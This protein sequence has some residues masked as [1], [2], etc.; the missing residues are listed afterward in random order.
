MLNRFADRY[1]AMP[2]QIIVETADEIDAS[3]GARERRR[4][5]QSRNNQDNRRID[6]LL[7]LL[8]QPRNRTGAVRVKLWLQQ[9]GRISLDAKSNPVAK[10]GRVVVDRD[11]LCPYS[12]KAIGLDA[13]FDAG[14]I[15]I[16][17]IIPYPQSLDNRLQNLALSYAGENLQKGNR[18][19]YEALRHDPARLETMKAA[20]AIQ[21]RSQRW[22]YGPDALE[23]YADETGGF[24]PRH[25]QDTRYGARVARRYLSTVADVVSVKGALTAMLR[26][27]WGLDSLI[28]EIGGFVPDGKA[29]E[30]SRLD[31]RHHAIDAA[32]LAVVDRSLVQRVATA[33]RRWNLAAGRQEA[34]EV[35]LPWPT[36]REDLKERLQRLV[37]SHQPD[38][39]VSGALH[40][41]TL[42]GPPRSK[43]ARELRADGVLRVSLE[44]MT[45][46]QAEEVL[47]PEARAKILDALKS[48]R[49]AERLAAEAE[50][51]KARP[52]SVAAAT[53]NIDFGLGT[54]PQRFRVAVRKSSITVIG[55]SGAERAVD[56]SSVHRVD[57]YE[58][59][60]GG[61][62]CVPMTMIDAAREEQGGRRS[63]Q[64]TQS[65]VRP[66]L[67]LHRGDTIALLDKD[68][69]SRVLIRVVKR[70]SPSD[71]N[72]CVMLASP[73]LAMSDSAYLEKVPFSA[74]RKR[75]ARTVSVC[76]IGDV[77]GLGELGTLR[78]E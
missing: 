72:R 73:C 47:I 62:R 45:E 26:R 51:R 11:A 60:K 37:V 53:A 8:R 71:S 65:A 52:V 75:K 40:N 7:D 76:P 57:F 14:T 23:R 19:P 67:S 33:I 78:R 74:L 64:R 10:D 56:A 36:F 1:G 15:Q 21:P 27:A 20:V 48:A 66:V 41:E 39:G 9:G 50:G 44:R 70:L 63:A 49:D 32:V 42:Y 69:P 5:N 22:R 35:D 59:G 25:L 77:K 29:G 24:L 43:N 16:D 18:T 2:E 38:R 30:K 28:G 13:L 6:G 54:K 34:I 68:D 4:K 61:W 31:L 3:E 17:H 58:D 55:R 46:G 12:G